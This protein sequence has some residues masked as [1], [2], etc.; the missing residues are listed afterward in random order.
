MPREV[1]LRGNGK[2]GYGM[3]ESFVGLC[4]EKWGCVATTRDLRECGRVC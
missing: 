3:R 2:A 4:P 1:G